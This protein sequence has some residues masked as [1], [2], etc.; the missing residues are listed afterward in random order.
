MRNLTTAISATVTAIVIGL[1][2]ANV[3]SAA[4]A[5]D[6]EH[7]KAAQL[8]ALESSFNANDQATQLAAYQ[9]RY[10]EAYN[11]LAAAY[12]ALLQR[13]WQYKDSLSRSD[14]QSAQL[15]AANASLEAQLAQAYRSLQD[16]QVAVSAWGGTPS[17]VTPT[18]LTPVVADPV[19]ADPV[20]AAAPAGPAAATKPA[21]PKPATAAPRTAA[22]A[23]PAAPPAASTPAPRVQYCHYDANHE[24][25]CEDHPW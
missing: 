10:T 11:Q 5:A 13:D 17:A 12:T 1:L 23:P 19:T 21:T 18:Q 15:A 8:A 9:Q 7:S 24:W 16:A 14:R 4:R 25:H 6:I 22:P 20:A 2:V 3:A